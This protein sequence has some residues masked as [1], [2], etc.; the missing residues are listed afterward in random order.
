[1]TEAEWLTCTDPGPMLEHLGGVGVRS[2]RKQRLLDCACVRRIWHLIVDER[3]RRAIEVAERHA[4]DVATNDELREAQGVALIAADEQ[5]EL[6]RSGTRNSYSVLAAAAHAAWEYRSGADPLGH[7]VEAIAW[8]G[9]TKYGP[10]ERRL[11]K[12]KY[13]GERENQ[14]AL[15]RDIFVNPFRPVPIASSWL[16][17]TVTAIT[18]G[19]YKE[20]AFDR[21]PVLGDALEES[22]CTSED[23]LSHFRQPGVHVRGC[24]ALDLVLEKE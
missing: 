8:E 17:P 23:I 2:D 10:P 14:A 16:T 13:A 11:A 24:W 1:M 15:V 3:G 12:V 7:A 5:A 22:G 19:I 9:L 21:V 20:K 4:D 6:G 18:T